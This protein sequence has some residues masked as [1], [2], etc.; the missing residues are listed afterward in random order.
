M[1]RFS[2][3]CNAHLFILLGWRHFIRIEDVRTV[4]SPY[5]CGRW[6]MGIWDEVSR[7][8]VLFSYWLLLMCGPC[9]FVHRRLLDNNSGALAGKSTTTKKRAVISYLRETLEICE[10]SVTYRWKLIHYNM[11]N[12][13]ISR[14]LKLFFLSENLTFLYVSYLAY[15]LHLTWG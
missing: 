13:F 5:D 4:R 9:T 7:S 8:A 3:A 14:R 1:A 11:V 6:S 2:M 10:H 12:W 15:I